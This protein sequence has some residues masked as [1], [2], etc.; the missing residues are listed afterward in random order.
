MFKYRLYLWSVLNKMIAKLEHQRSDIKFLLIKGEHPC[1]IYE[2]LHKG[3]GDVWLLCFASY[4][5]VSQFY[6]GWTSVC[7]KPSSGKPAGAVI[8]AMAGNSDVFLVQGHQVTK[9]VERI[10][11]DKGS[12]CK[13][14]F[15][16]KQIRMSQANG[17]RLSRQLIGIPSWQNSHSVNHFKGMHLWT[18]IS[19]VTQY[20]CIM[21][22]LKQEF[23][24]WKQASSLGHRSLNCLLLLV[25]SCWFCSYDV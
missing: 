7:D 12:A 1:H 24:R 16:Y 25:R 14:I 13:N 11:I 4:R 9:Q 3:I 17:T 23:C 6:S 21:L 22:N 19:L 10:S 18:E 2:T 5:W 8:P 15:F 20:E